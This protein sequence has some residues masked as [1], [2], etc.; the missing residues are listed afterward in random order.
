MY[1]ASPFR[2]SVASATSAVAISEGTFE[3]QVTAHDPELRVVHEHSEN[4]HGS[5]AVCKRPDRP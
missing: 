1:P 2:L 4:V 5:A 3:D